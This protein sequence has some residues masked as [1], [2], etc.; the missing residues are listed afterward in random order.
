MADIDDITGD[1]AELARF[2][3]AQATMLLEDTHDVAIKGQDR[4]TSEPALLEAA[5]RLSGA[6]KDLTCLAAT[7]TVLLTPTALNPP[8]T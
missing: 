5:E 1:R 2:L 6:A 3:F 8:S 7:I 4:L